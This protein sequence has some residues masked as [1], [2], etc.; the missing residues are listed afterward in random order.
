MYCHVQR[1][2]DNKTQIAGTNVLPNLP[3]KPK[4]HSIRHKYNA[5][6]L[7][8]Q[9]SVKMYILCIYF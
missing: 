8:L 7:A 3:F 5:V 2:Q 9:N 4:S 1:E 6:H